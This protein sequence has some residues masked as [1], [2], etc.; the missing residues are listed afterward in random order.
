[1]MTGIG[2][3]INQSSIPLP[4]PMWMSSVLP[5]S[6]RAQGQTFVGPRCSVGSPRSDWT[7]GCGN[8]RYSKQNGRSSF[9]AGPPDRRGRG[10]SGVDAPHAPTPVC[11]AVDLRA[12]KTTPQVGGRS[13]HQRTGPSGG[14]WQRVCSRPLGYT[15][16]GGRRYRGR[17]GLRMRAATS[18]N[19]AASPPKDPR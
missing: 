5:A 6:A 13:R 8:L 4:K 12:S 15:V 18:L 7:F 3:P 16:S 11:W 9:V 17:N 10:R 2:T 14:V 1:M 19:R